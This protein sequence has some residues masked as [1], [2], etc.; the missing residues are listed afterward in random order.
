MHAGDRPEVPSVS[1]R[2]YTFKPHCFLTRTDRSPHAGVRTRQ[3][4]LVR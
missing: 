3:V 2:S 1:K 4:R